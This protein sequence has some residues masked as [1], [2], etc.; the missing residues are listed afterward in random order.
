MATISVRVDDTVKEKA[1]KIF[2]NI[3]L[4]VAS[5]TNLFYHQVVNYGKIPFEPIAQND[6]DYL[7]NIPQMEQSIIKGLS[8]PKKKL[9]KESKLKW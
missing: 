4:S 3:G 2:E 8:T 5:A 7:Q 6:T 9:F 1:Q